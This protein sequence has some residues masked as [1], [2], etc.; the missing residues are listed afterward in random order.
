MNA[1]LVAKLA[2]R[3]QTIPELHLLGDGYDAILERV[4]RDPPTPEERVARYLSARWA[5]PPSTRWEIRKAELRDML[6]K[7]F[8]LAWA[9]GMRPDLRRT[10]GLVG[11]H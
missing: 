10:R 6:G 5:F 3:R 7:Q 11:V 1:R 8:Q 4:D 9:R 2:R